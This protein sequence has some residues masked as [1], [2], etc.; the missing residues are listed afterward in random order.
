MIRRKRPIIFILITTLVVLFIVNHKNFLPTSNHITKKASPSL[1]V[2][3]QLFNTQNWIFNPKTPQVQT[4]LKAKSIRYLNK[5]QQSKMSQPYI[6][7]TR[8]NAQYVISSQKAHSDKETELTFLKQVVMKQFLAQNSSQNK[9]LRSQQFSYNVQT[10]MATSPVL[11]TVS[12]KG[13]STSGVG[14]KANIKQDTIHF[15]SKVTTH[16]E[17]QHTH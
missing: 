4:Y 10:Q 11:V 12:Q 3:W 1:K 8:P 17:P 9:T 13:L 6:I 16:Y 15:S 5:K 7:Q 2:S 14:L